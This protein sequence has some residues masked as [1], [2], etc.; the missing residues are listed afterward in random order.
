MNGLPVESGKEASS[1]GGQKTPIRLEQWGISPNDKDRFIVK[2]KNVA[3]HL[4]RNALGGQN[5]EQVT[6]LLT[7]PSPFSRRYR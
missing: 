1:N 2:D 5:E 6:A 7:L 4:V 3:T